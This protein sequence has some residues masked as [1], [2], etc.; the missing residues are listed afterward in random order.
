M[1]RLFEDGN[2]IG[3]H[4]LFHFERVD[5]IITAKNIYYP[6][7]A[8]PVEGYKFALWLSPTTTGWAGSTYLEDPT[9]PSSKIWVAYP[10]GPALDVIANGGYK[11][12]AFAVY[13]KDYIA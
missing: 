13:I 11:V 5:R 6:I 3:V 1:A 8:K 7:V 12:S 10:V 2:E 4:G 9:N